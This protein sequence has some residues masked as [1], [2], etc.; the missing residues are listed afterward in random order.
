MSSFRLRKMLLS[1]ALATFLIP[2]LASAGSITVFSTDFESGAPSEVS[3]AG[4]VESSQGLSAFGFGNSFYRNAAPGNPTA[5]STVI[6]LTGLQ[7]H[8]SIDLNFLF[9]ALDSWDTGNPYADVFNVLVDG[10]SIFSEGFAAN[11]SGTFTADSA[12]VTLFEN[13][14]LY[15]GTAGFYEAA[16]DMGLQNVFNNIAHTGS[17][18][19]IE[20]FASSVDLAGVGGTP[21]GWSGGTD[22]SFA[23]DNI[24]IILN[25][26]ATANVPEPATSGLL[27][28]GMVL[29][30][31][32]RRRRVGRVSTS[33]V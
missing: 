6:S 32:R 25:G 2:S 16:Y 26:V 29:L 11:G 19:T 15:A 21:N 31:M 8:T 3:G 18:L 12:G 20:F 33:L 22:E 13:L 1:G 14:P 30:G 9:A 5:P 17:D 27:G 24:E 4:G 23:L 28:L 7:S 10:T